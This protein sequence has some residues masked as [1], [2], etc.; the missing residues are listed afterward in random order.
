MPIAPRVAREWVGTNRSVS[1]EE[2]HPPTHHLSPHARAAEQ[3]SPL[4]EPTSTRRTRDKVVLPHAPHT[5][6]RDAIPKIFLV[7]RARDS[8]PDCPLFSL[9]FAL[10][11]QVFST[12]PLARPPH[13]R[14]SRHGAFERARCDCG[15]VR[16]RTVRS[17]GLPLFL[18]AGVGLKIATARAVPKHC[19][20]NSNRNQT[21]VHTQ[22]AG[23]LHG[24][25]AGRVQL[26]KRAARDR[27]P[28]LSTR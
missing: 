10:F 7:A 3:T 15:C 23:A 12:P 21:H 19:S 17:T 4:I 20:L 27:G 11:R 13:P 9:S 25:L 16:V 1:F 8:H 18:S 28:T 2:L 5:L 14:A 22:C 26:V 6:A 24:A